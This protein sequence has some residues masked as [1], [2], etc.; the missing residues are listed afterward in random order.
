ML[1]GI[2]MVRLIVTLDRQQINDKSIG[3]DKK[4]VGSAF[5][6]DTWGSD[7]LFVSGDFSDDYSITIAQSDEMVRFPKLPQ[8]GNGGLPAAC[9]L[10]ID[11][12]ASP[13]SFRM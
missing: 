4:K 12:C 13:D 6:I 3:G 11:A 9:Y 5:R 2:I 1:S 8:A 7:C 10:E